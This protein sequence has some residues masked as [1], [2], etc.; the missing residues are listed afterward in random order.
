MGPVYE[1]PGSNEGIENAAH[2]DK[3]IC[4]AHKVH[5]LTAIITCR[6]QVR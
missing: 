6:C 5:L 4:D 1:Y 2:A 3:V